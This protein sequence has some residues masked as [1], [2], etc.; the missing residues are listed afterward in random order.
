MQTLIFCLVLWFFREKISI[1]LFFF[2]V[3]ENSYF[4]RFFDC[5]YSVHQ[6]ETI[7]LSLSGIANFFIS[8]QLSH[9]SLTYESST[10][11]DGCFQQK[12]F[13]K[14]RQV[15]ILEFL[16]FIFPDVL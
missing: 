12:V 7:F 5:V 2:S 6:Y 9:L 15:I 3:Y 4:L 8:Q 14:I 10:K 13:E 1:F 16:L 11:N